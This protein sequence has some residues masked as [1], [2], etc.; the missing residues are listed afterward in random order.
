MA[1]FR[2][3]LFDFDG[4]LADTETGIVTTFKAALERMG[5]PVLSSEAIKATIGL[6]LDQSFHVA[7]GLEGDR[8]KLATDTYREIFQTVGFAS[9]VLF[10]GVKE[11]LETLRQQGM[12]LGIASSRHMLSLLQICDMQGITHLFDAIYG[13]DKAPR[14][15]PA[16]DTVLAALD[17]LG[18]SPEETLV[19][20]DTIF[21]LQMGKNAGCRVCGVTYGNHSRE[22]LLSEAPD[23]L[24]DDLRELCAIIDNQ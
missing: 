22:R 18:I 24:V 12:V 9:I 8:I 16:P 20:G 6:P 13:V 7:A 23:F 21:D 2:C 19:V 11:A 3:I 10:E 14:P 15:K 17:E 1:Q 4:T 5:E